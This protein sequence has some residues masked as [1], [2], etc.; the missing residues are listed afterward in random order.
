[1]KTLIISASPFKN[2]RS[3]LLS[4]EVKKR[5]ELAGIIDCDF[6]HPYRLPGDSLLALDISNDSIKQA[7][8][9]VRNASIIIIITPI[10]QASISG[11]LK[12]FV[13]LLPQNALRGKSILPIAIGGS[14]RHL[15]AVE[16]GLVPILRSLAAGWIGACIFA[17][18]EQ[19]SKGESPIIPKELGDRLDQV[20][21]FVE[22]AIAYKKITSLFN[23]KINFEAR[24]QVNA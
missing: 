4:S 22:H 21:P 10:F 2:S 5:L 6:L 13:D 9:L 15:L 8:E 12:L 18:S 17:T 24:D 14:Y 23:G 16:Y 11:G 19:I 3:E 20:M 1:V 7:V